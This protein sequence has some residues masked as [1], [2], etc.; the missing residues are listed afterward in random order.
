MS[1]RLSSCSRLAQKDDKHANEAPHRLDESVHESLAEVLAILV[2][3]VAGLVVGDLPELPVSGATITA[4]V[5]ETNTPH[6]HGGDEAAYGGEEYGTLPP[7]C[8]YS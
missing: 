7:K 8:R 4:S 1:L 3:V 2:A 6:L 5:P